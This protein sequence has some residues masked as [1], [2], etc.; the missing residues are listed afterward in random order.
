MFEKFWKMIKRNKVESATLED[1]CKNAQKV[2][3][4]YGYTLVCPEDDVEFKISL[5]DENCEKAKQVAGKYG[6]V[7]VCDE[8]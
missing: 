5:T 3:Y 2:A 6:F 4:R 1:G 8:E 7:V